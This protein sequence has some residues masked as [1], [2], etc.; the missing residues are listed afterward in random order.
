MCIS[1]FTSRYSLAGAR[2]RPSWRPS[3]GVQWPEQMKTKT[4]VSLLVIL[5]LA[6]GVWAAEKHFS[7]DQIYDLVRRKLA[8][9]D[10]GGGKALFRRSDLRPGQAQAGRRRGGKG[11]RDGGRSQRRRRHFEGQSRIRRAEDQG[12]ETRA[13]GLRR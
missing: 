2:S 8:D 11:W 12:G 5:T 6:A 7:D 9:D 10:L 3:T 13:Q 4:L 1:T